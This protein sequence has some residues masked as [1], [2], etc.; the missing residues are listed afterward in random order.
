MIPEPIKQRL[1]DNWGDKAN[2]MECFAE[3]KFIDTI[4]PWCC[5]I[6]ALNPDD[7][8]TICCISPYGHEQVHEW[9]LKE[10][11]NSHDIHGEQVFMD[12]EYRRIKAST[13][14]RKIQGRL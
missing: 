6:Y 14:C 2:A 12:T 13:L 1:Y 3:V 5:Y 9:S 4:S 11:V 7:N 10:L 8:D